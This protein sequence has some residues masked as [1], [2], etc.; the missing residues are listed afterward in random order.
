MGTI[1]KLEVNGARMSGVEG[2]CRCISL[3]CVIAD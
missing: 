2:T 1:V 3:A